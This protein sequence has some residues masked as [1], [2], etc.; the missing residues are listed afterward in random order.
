MRV[1]VEPEKKT[2]SMIIFIVPFFS[3]FPLLKLTHFSISFAIVVMPVFI[4]V[5]PASHYEITYIKVM[6]RVK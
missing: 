1:I 2:T 6:K 3:L 5:S 4:Y